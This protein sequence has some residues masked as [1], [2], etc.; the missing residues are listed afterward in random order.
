MKRGFS[1]R[2]YHNKSN[3]ITYAVGFIV[4]SGKGSKVFHS[5]GLTQSTK[6]KKTSVN[7]LLGLQQQYP[8]GEYSALHLSVHFFASQHALVL[9]H[10]LNAMQVGCLSLKKPIKYY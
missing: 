5:A 9:R 10:W 6:K 1:K 3:P 8:R 7:S 2:N 4:I